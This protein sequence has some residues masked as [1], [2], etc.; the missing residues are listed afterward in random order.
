MEN[1][2]SEV[3]IVDEIPIEDDYR[4]DGYGKEKDGLCVAVHQV[5]ASLLLMRMIDVVW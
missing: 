1:A 3:A 2:D 5:E 4:G